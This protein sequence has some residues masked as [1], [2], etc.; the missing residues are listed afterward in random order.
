MFKKIILFTACVLLI[1]GFFFVYC[2]EKASQ[3][4]E[5]SN[6]YALTKAQ[7]DSLQEGDIIF[8]HGFGII[9]DAIVKYSKDPYRI[10]HCGI[11]VKDSA[12]GWAVIHTVSN[13]LA[14]IDGMQMDGLRKFVRES[15]PESIIVTRYRFLNA[16]QQQRLVNQ[17]YYYL[18]KRIPF[19]NEFNS[20]DSTKFFCTELI[21]NIF[22]HAIGI[23]LYLPS[24][25][26]NGQNFAA[27]L[28][29]G[30]FGVVL[31]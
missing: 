1:G 3:K 10:S 29:E 14:E 6:T 20:S 11:V 2:Y 5:K 26:Y 4:K 31:E 16:E 30:N 21:W 15:Q 17:A 18:S 19:D 7:K 27:F 28:D 24:P 9:S 25:H 12:G 8:R 13:S 23:D 22:Y